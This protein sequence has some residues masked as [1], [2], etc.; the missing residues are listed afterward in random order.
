MFFTSYPEWAG[1][2]TQLGEGFSNMHNAPRFTPS[3]T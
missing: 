2:V 1:D 3:T